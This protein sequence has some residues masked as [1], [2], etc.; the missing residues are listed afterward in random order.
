MKR[1]AWPVICVAVLAGFAAQ[2][3]E[4]PEVVEAS[5]ALAEGVP[6]VSVIRLRELLGRD[7]PPAARAATRTKLAEALVAAEQP[8]EAIQLL[9][10]KDAEHSSS[11]N[12]LRG[13]ALAALGRWS[14][15]LPAYQRAQANPR[16][17][18]AAQAMMGEAEAARALGRIDDALRVLATLQR[19]PTWR[20]RAQLRSVALL[21][22]KNDT[23]RAVRS[24]AETRAISVREK[25]E[26]RFL[27]GRLEA[28]LGHREKAIELFGTILQKPEGAD[29]AVLVGSLFAL[30]DIH[31]ELKTPEVGDDALENFIDHYGTS[32]GLAPVFAKLDQLYGAE[33]KPSRRELARWASDAVQPRRALAQWYLARLELRAGR[34]DDAL[35]AFAQL[36]AGGPQTRELVEAF[37]QF[38]QLRADDGRFD[39]ALA[40]L[41]DARALHPDAAQSNR[42]HLL[43][44]EFHYRAGRWE[45]AARTFE[46]EAKSAPTDATDALYN[47]AAAWLQMKDTVRFLADAR[48]LG[49]AGANDGTRG[50]LALEQGLVR[51]AQND[52]GAEEALRTFTKDFPK[53]A[54][55]SEA[56]VALAELAFHAAPPRVSEAQKLLARASEN[57]PTPIASERAD[58]LRIWIADAT[59]DPAGPNAISLASEFLGR[60]AD[61]TF[62]PDV[63]LKLAEA[64][65]RRHDFASA[66]TQFELLARGNAAG[67]YAEKA[68]FFAAE[69]ALQSMGADSLERAL[70]L[71]DEVVKRGGEL[72]WAARNEQAVAERKM[73]KAPDAITLYEEVLKSDAKPAEK[74]EALCGKADILYETA[75]SDRT[76]YE[77]ALALYQELA[78]EP[79][80]APH[81][82]NQALFKAGTCLEKMGERP[83]ALE[84]FYSVI[85]EQ[86][87]AEKAREY[88]WFFKAGFN[89]ASMLEDDSK[90][91]AAASVYEKLAAAGGDRSDE[92]KTRLAR[93]RLEHFLWDH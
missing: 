93:L 54:R 34:R 82:R 26:K 64:S 51:A 1:S 22:E 19:E 10:E 14:E 92:G 62:A 16:Q 87:R 20:V 66:Q 35:R 44:G 59:P 8:A 46:A 3:E 33:R 5:R 30:A 63:R 29:Y 83:R 12:F 88:F 55:V 74:R 86:G 49:A 85:E 2:A 28:A 13:Q 80:A 72:K 25:K 15:A 60:Y 17:P 45:T 81:W 18:F 69:S 38:A 50:D 41:D 90:W 79:N 42:L 24:L 48:E 84:T 73:G 61:S 4:F 57:S 89:A 21:I 43:A 65:F 31:L 76:K 37:V 70:T 27:R 11:T 68:L 47:A 9:E 56:L 58:Y 32:A 67:P 6:Q 23:S 7:L 75:G 91:D 36:R 53:H 52:R 77:A 39:E 40:I 71:L 78:R